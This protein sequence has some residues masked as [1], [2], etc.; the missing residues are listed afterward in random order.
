M[1]H[2]ALAGTARGSNGYMRQQSLLDWLA[3]PGAPVLVI[4]G[5]ETHDIYPRRLPP[6][7]SCLAPASSCRR[8]RTHADDGR[9]QATGKWLLKFAATG[10]A[11]PH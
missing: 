5:S 11:H 9:P 3:A 4:F 10:A 6:T 7:A 2:R 8:R 1:T